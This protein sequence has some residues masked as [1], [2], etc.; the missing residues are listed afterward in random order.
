MNL[1]MTEN[2]SLSKHWQIHCELGHNGCDF[3]HLL[4]LINDRLLPQPKLAVWSG[5]V[6][7]LRLHGLRNTAG[8]R[9]IQRKLATQELSEY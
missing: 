1:A 6:Q 5:H 8:T 3:L 4:R 9:S 7:S 2:F